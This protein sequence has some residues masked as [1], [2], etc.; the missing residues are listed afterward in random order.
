[1]CGQSLHLKKDCHKVNRAS[2]VIYEET[3]SITNRKSLI[4]VGED[5]PYNRRR[6]HLHEKFL[7]PWKMIY[8]Y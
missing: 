6:K 8:Y 1:M 2:S 4:I 7:V 5:G 3:D